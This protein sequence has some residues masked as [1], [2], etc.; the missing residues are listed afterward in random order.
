MML[1]NKIN[2]IKRKSLR[3][4]QMKNFANNIEEVFV[5]IITKS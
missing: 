5:L 1:L 2:I 3:N 4:S